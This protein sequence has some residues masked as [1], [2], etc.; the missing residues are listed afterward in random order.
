[1]TLRIPAKVLLD[2]HVWPY[3][4]Y[5]MTLS[6]GKRRPHVL[7][8]FDIIKTATALTNQVYLTTKV[9]RIFPAKCT[10]SSMH[11]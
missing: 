10:C 1:M 8:H 3:D 4:F 9:C 7:G 2:L 5:N 11:I 6:T